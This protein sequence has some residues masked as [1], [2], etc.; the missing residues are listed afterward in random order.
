MIIIVCTLCQQAYGNDLFVQFGIFLL[1]WLPND[2]FTSPLTSMVDWLMHCFHSVDTY[3][4]VS[5]FLD[6]AIV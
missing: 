3:L 6:E 4:Q 1:L 5:M 2:S